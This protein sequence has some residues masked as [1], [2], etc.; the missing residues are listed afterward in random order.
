MAF[1][2]KALAAEWDRYH[3]MRA[4]DEEDRE[5]R[6]RLPPESY[7][8][9]TCQGFELGSGAT[10]RRLSERWVNLGCVHEHV[11]AQRLCAFHED[12]IRLDELYCG[13]CHEAACDCRVNRLPEP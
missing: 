1:S 2:S 4:A 13:E 3:A 8:D 12:S 7:P 11:G 10:C 6:E 5:L 9:Y